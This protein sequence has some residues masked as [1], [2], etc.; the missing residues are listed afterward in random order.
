MRV[1]EA[2]IVYRQTGVSF[3]GRRKI[4]DAQT[5]VD[6]IRQ[7]VVA[8]NREHFVALFLDA[9]R[10]VLGFQ[11]VHIGTLNQSLVSPREVFQPAIVI[12]AAAIVAAHNHPSGDP[13]PSPEDRRVTERLCEAGHLIGIDVLDH[14]VW[15]SAG[16]FTS[17]AQSGLIDE[18]RRR[19]QR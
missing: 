16:A 1:R 17:F 19:L 14:I 11:R 8:E 15:T 12:G 6:L 9:R 3:D 18:I 2:E 10:S 4:T 13:S 5:A 7:L